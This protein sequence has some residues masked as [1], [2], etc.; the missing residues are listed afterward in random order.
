MT[1]DI[2]QALLGFFKK[3]VSDF[4]L[5]EDLKQDVLLKIVQAGPKEEIQ[6]L[7]SW[8]FRIAQNTLIDH[9]RKA[10]LSQVELG[11]VLSIEEEESGLKDELLYCLTSYLND[12]DS[13]SAEL[14]RKVDFQ[15]I[16]QKVLAKSMGLN[17][18]SLRSRVQRARKKLHEKFISNC[19]ISFDARG[20]IKDC[21]SKN[22]CL[23]DC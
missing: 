13:E 20:H 3:R 2:D 8:V 22:P 18:P 15:N 9:Y 21:Q 5:A 11:E 23:D 14:L 10:K 19:E 1:K 12:L 16:P 17:Y 4:Q 6:N 7:Q